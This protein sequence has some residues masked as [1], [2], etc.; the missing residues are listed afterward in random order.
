MIII[1]YT[2]K[3]DLC[4]SSGWSLLLPSCGWEGELQ[5]TENARLHVVFTFKKHINYRL[6]KRAKADK[7]FWSERL[8][9][10]AAHQRLISPERIK[11]TMRPLNEETNTLLFMVL[12]LCI[13]FHTYVVKWHQI[14]HLACDLEC[15]GSPTLLTRLACLTGRSYFHLLISILFLLSTSAKIHGVMAKVCGLGWKWDEKTCSNSVCV[16]VRFT[17]VLLVR[18]VLYLF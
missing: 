5:L 9:Q 11:S 7:L 2:I 18:P 16:C 4:W 15:C 1:H 17:L 6:V 3:S 8:V 13:I 14:L 12:L 10:S